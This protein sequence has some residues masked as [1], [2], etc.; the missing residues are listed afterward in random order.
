MRKRI[1]VAVAG[2]IAGL[3]IGSLLAYFTGWRWWVRLSVAI[4]PAIALLIAERKR[5][6]RTPEELNRPTTIFDHQ[7]SD[8]DR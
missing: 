2:G 3:L 8:T 7:R 4:A 6:I 5:F 1:L